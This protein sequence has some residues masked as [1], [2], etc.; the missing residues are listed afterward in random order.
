MP[1]SRGYGRAPSL[2]HATTV[3]QTLGFL[4]GQVSYISAHGIT[5]SAVSSPGPRLEAF[6]QTEGITVHGV[7]MPRR[8]TPVGDMK[9]VVRLWH[10]FIRTMPQI[11]H[12][13][14][15][16][17][18]LLAMIS[19]RLAGVPVSVYH[20]HGMPYVTQTGVKRTLLKS[21]EKISCALATQVLCVSDSVRE[22]AVRDS[23]CP[24][25]KIKVL[26][27]GS[28]NGVDADGRFNPAR[29]G[30]AG[31]EAR[32]RY[33]IPEDAP[34]VGFIGR[35]VR[36]KGLVELVEAWKVLRDEF[37]ALHLLVVGPF[38][39]QDPVPAETEAVLRSDARIHLT[40]RQL[41]TPPL[42]AA[43]DVLCLPTYREGFPNVPLEA[44][45]MELPV[46][47][48]RIPGCVDAVA[49]GETG[50]LVPP[51]DAAA[52]ADAL[53]AYLNDTD[54]RRRHGQA[55]RARVLR[56]FRQE[57]IWEAMYQE[58]VRLLQE[59]GLPVPQPTGA[60]KASV[61]DR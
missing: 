16:K 39:P 41:D 40:G 58:Y 11:V 21:T 28:I 13:H 60:E 22:V 27:G 31:R 38:E 5:I 54:L 52:L 61:T 15:P 14:T 18:G 19:A 8:I 53:R 46:A 12:A 30:A 59:K 4:C 10:H 37:P 48:T 20:I 43:M 49:D 1:L 24:A 42:F 17:G 36:D 32:A 44:A 2:L 23:I 57:A 34:V 50:T 25:H 56:E 35:I 26:L 51:R 7:R 6:G 55:G 3:P 47:A 33:D 45:A 29:V 9:A